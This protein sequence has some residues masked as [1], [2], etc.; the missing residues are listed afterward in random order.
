MRSRKVEL[1]SSCLDCEC[2]TIPAHSISAHQD[3]RIPPET[4]QVFFEQIRSTLVRRS[5]W[6]SSYL[7]PGELVILSSGVPAENSGSESWT[8]VK[9]LVAK[10]VWAFLGNL[11]GK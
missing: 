1:E 7:L 3:P 11:T 4:K 6:E 5:S 9:L 2:A 10:T 8:L